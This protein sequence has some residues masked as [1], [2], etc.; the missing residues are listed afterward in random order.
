MCSIERIWDW[1]CVRVSVRMIQLEDRWSDLDEI[2]NGR[3]VIGGLS[4]NLY[5]LINHN[6]YFQHGMADTRD[7]LY[8][9][10]SVTGERKIAVR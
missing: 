9:M 4:Q 5:F 10:R 6:R 7:F 8:M 3:Y 1:S 2:W